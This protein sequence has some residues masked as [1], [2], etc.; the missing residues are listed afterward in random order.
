MFVS[1]GPIAKPSP[2]QKE[3]WYYVKAD[4][5]IGDYYNWFAKRGLQKGWQPCLNGCHVTF[6]AGEKDDRIISAAEVQPY[7][8]E[9]IQFYYTNK[10]WTNTQAFWLPV[11]SSQL[12]EIRVALGLKPRF[13]YHV[14]LGNI[15][16]RIPG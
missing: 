7:L 8:G 14:T 6:I 16:N 5:Q 9:E 3:G 15:K 2:S 13:L 12:D 4:D 1:Y 10:I 11:L